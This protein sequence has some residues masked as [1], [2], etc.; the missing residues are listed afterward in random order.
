LSATRFTVRSLIR[1]LKPHRL[2]HHLLHA[3]RLVFKH[4]ATGKEMN[5][6]AP[7]PSL[8]REIVAQL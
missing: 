3:A 8:I 4:P 1:S 5:L 2:K 7:L 6:Q